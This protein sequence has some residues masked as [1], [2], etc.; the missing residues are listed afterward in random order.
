MSCQ[1][2]AMVLVKGEDKVK[3]KAHSETGQEGTAGK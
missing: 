2:D 3:G 1:Y